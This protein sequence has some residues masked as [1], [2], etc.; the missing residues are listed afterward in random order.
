MKALASRE[1]ELKDAAERDS[2]C[3]KE[4]RVRTYHTRVNECVLVLG[5]ALHC[6][7]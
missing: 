7:S 6:M 1:R 3:H 4:M 2:T 5:A